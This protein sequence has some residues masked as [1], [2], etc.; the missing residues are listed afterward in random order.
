MVPKPSILTDLLSIQYLPRSHFSLRACGLAGSIACNNV[1]KQK[2]KSIPGCER[3]E[4]ILP[5][6]GE[7]G[8]CDLVVGQ[9]ID[10]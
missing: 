10:V 8:L 5:E 2:K 4:S 9:S 6:A 1:I 7:M 3:K